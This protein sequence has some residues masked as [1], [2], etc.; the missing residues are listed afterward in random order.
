MALPDIVDVLGQ[1]PYPLKETL[2]EYLQELRDRIV[3]ETAQ[4]E[5]DKAKKEADAAA[6]A[7]AETPLDKKEGEDSNNSK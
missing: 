7:A 4:A 1:R 3:E 2:L 6:T 5:A